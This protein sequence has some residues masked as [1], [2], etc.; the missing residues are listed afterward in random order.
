MGG[1][2]AFGPI[3]RPCP[4]V[5]LGQERFSLR[6]IFIYSALSSQIIYNFLLPHFKV[7]SSEN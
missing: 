1:D 2:M 6:I 4:V 5:L 3:Y 7:L